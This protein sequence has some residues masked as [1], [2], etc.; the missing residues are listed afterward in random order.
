M[1]KT[2][3]NRITALVLALFLMAGCGTSGQSTLPVDERPSPT[4]ETESP[5]DTLLTQ[6]PSSATNTLSPTKIPI[7]PPISPTPTIIPTPTPK[8]EVITRENISQMAMLKRLDRGVV[9]QVGYSPDGK[10]IMVVTSLE[11]ILYDAGTLAEQMH[12]KTD[13]APLSA[14]ISPDG[15]LLAAGYRDGLVTIWDIQNGTALSSFNDHDSQAS[16]VAFS[17]D[18]KWFASGARDKTILLRNA[19][20]WSIVHVLKRHTDRITQLAFSPDSRLLASSALD[21]TARLWNVEDGSVIATLLGHTNQVKSVAFSPD[22]QYIL[23]GSS[24]SS[25][26]LWDATDGTLLQTVEEKLNAESVTFSPDGEFIAAG[27]LNNTID[28]CKFTNGSI[29]DCRLVGEANSGS[30]TAISISPG[31]NQLVSGGSTP[32]V[33]IWDFDELQ[34]LATLGGFAGM[35]FISDDAISPSLEMIAFSSSLDSILVQDINDQSKNL[36]LNERLA[37]NPAFSSDGKKLAHVSFRTIKVWDLETS[38]LLTIVE[39]S[40]SRIF[41]IAVS[42]NGQLLAA[43]SDEGTVHLW[44]SNDGNSHRILEGHTKSV[45]QVTFS[46]DGTLI[47]SGSEDRSVRVWQVENG[48]LSFSFDNLEGKILCIGFI[49]DGSFLAAGTDT[50]VIYLWRVSDGEMVWKVRIDP[51][52][53]EDIAFHP[54]DQIMAA[55]TAKSV[56]VQFLDLENGKTLYLL[57]GIKDENSYHVD[58]PIARIAFSPD[59]TLLAVFTREAAM[60]YWGFPD[61]VSK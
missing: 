61:A 17:P 46:P 51:Q 41:D 23:T 33:R 16:A 22:G 45:S 39:G 36:E 48:E 34:L 8:G 25:M 29:S 21:Q 7:Q 5:H 11:I 47:A 27:I 52:P 12:F 6:E 44:K 19:Q 1:E 38:E 28:V 13:A 55:I 3:K 18:G 58:R 15:S 42:H 26:R 24:D 43:A 56:T 30:I 32:Y 2:M 31:G 54:G 49:P 20:D 40:E 4:F 35:N 53:V 10:K 50:G 60:Y 59:G 9:Q 14:A 57:T 37:S